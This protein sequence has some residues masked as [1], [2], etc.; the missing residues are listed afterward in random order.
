MS[1]W[2][3]VYTSSNPHRAEI[4]KDI[5]TNAQIAATV[6][7]L[8]DSSYQL[9]RLEVRVSPDAI[10]KAIKIISEEIKFDNE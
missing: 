3:T 10:L 5:L 1:N 7:N 9:G 6:I 4:V 8:K 2:Q